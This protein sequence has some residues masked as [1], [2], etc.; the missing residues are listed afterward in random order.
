[1]AHSAPRCL[2]FCLLISCS[3][4]GRTESPEAVKNEAMSYFEA[5]RALMLGIQPHDVTV[6]IEESVLI[7]E[8]VVPTEIRE[9]R[10]RRDDSGKFLFFTG[11]ERRIPI[12]D[13]LNGQMDR[14]VSAARVLLIQEGDVSNHLLSRGVAKRDYPSFDAA[15]DVEKFPRLESFGLHEFARTVWDPSDADDTVL[16]VLT[17]ASSLTVTP[18]LEGEQEQVNVKAVLI[19][20][21]LEETIYWKFTSLGIAPVHYSVYQ[22]GFLPTQRKQKIFEQDIQWKNHDL[23]GK[24]PVTVTIAFDARIRIQDKASDEENESGPPK[25]KFIYTQKYKDVRMIWND[26]GASSD[27]ARFVRDAYTYADVDRSLRDGK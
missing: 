10:I 11:S 17:R 7:D 26:F 25:T 5:S 13:S 16:R 4:T 20:D 9:W 1:M 24:V 22:Q 27:N 3:T 8:V 15:C 6:K 2:L 19:D 14:W 21:R 12:T 18:D 23:Y